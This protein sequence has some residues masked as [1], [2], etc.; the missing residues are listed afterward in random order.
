[1]TYADLTQYLTADN[2]KEYA[3]L[4]DKLVFC[5]DLTGLSVDSRL[6]ARFENDLEKIAIVLNYMK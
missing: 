2:A 3:S 1:M 4:T 5:S 6:L